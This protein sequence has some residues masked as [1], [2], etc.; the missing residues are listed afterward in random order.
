MMRRI[1]FSNLLHRPL[2][3]LLSVILLAFGT[4]IISLLLVLNHAFQQ[5]MDR[6]L[7]DID[8]VIGAKGSPLQLVL[9]AVYHLD[10]PTGNI[11]MSEVKKLQANKQI[12]KITPL[13]YGDN[14]QG[15]RILGTDHSYIEKYRATLRDGSL[16]EKDFE[17]VVGADI[18]RLKN[19]KTGDT[20]VGTHGSDARAHAHEEH[21]YKVVGV[22]RP[23]GTVLDQ[24]VLC[25]T[26]TVWAIHHHPEEDHQEEHDHDH[27]DSHHDH[28][29][30][31]DHDHQA[32]DTQEPQELTALLVQLRNPMALLTL[33]RT[34]NENSTLQ[35]A[36]PSLEINRLANLTG[37]G[38]SLL[39]GIA[40]GIILISAL[41]IFIT[42]FGRIR[43]RQY[44]MAVIRLMG[45]SRIQLAFMT[46]TEAWLIAGIGYLAGLVLS[47][48]GLY[49]L[50][51]QVGSGQTWPISYNFAPPEY[52]LFPAVLLLSTLSALIPAI[53]AFRIN[54]S[55]TLSNE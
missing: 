6:D 44:E 47:R 7:Q 12:K 9:S 46:L 37:I 23:S 49:I 30:E 24:L 41:S 27:E 51:S 28:D 33:P 54:I 53:Q 3:T 42:I 11:P 19:L 1:I 18:A 14:Y 20:F 13:A 17:V 22:L 4:A 21:P 39:Q 45:G 34:I 10:A 5:K 25:T 31:H 15:Y 52:Y 2:S 16:F 40:W 8:L 35:A 29:H 43:D 38:T 26:H 55:K 50:Q 32:A 48:A 36:V